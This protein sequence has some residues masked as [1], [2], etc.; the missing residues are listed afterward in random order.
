MIIVIILA[1]CLQKEIFVQPIVYVHIIATY[2]LI[3]GGFGLKSLFTHL[4]P[5]AHLKA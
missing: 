5:I 4:S 2:L 1:D 3:R